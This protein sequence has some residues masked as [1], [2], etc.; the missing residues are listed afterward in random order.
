M[1]PVTPGTLRT[2]SIICF[3]VTFFISAKQWH[4]GQRLRCNRRQSG[5]ISMTTKEATST[6]ANWRALD[7]PPTPEKKSNTMMTSFWS[8]WDGMFPTSSIPSSRATTSVN[9]FTLSLFAKTVPPPVS[10]ASDAVTTSFSSAFKLVLFI[11]CKA[12][13][14]RTS[15]TTPLPIFV[16]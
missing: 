4:P 12:P 2:R 8:S 7:S 6:L 1:M 15:S 14:N 13:T 5:S 16:I 9:P 11:G 10:H 3:F